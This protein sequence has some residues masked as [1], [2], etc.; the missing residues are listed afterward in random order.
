MA[1]SLD[2]Y[3][4]VK[5]RAQSGQIGLIVLLIMVVLLTMGLSIAAQTTQELFLSSQTSDSARVFN[6]A[7]AGIEQAL[8]TDL[9]FAQQVLEGE[10]T[11]IPNTDVNYSISKINTLQ[12][13]LFEGITVMVDV[14]GVVNGQAIRIDWS[15]DGDCNT[16]D[17]ASLLV[18]VYS[19]NAGV[20]SMRQ[21]A[22]GACNRSDGFTLASTLTPAQNNLYRRYDLAL[23]TND[24]FVRIKPVYNDTDIRVTGHQGFTL[25]TQ[26]YNIRSEARSQTG[27]ETRIVEVN[28]TLPT[29]PSI[30]DY[31]LYSGGSLNK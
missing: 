14:T 11:S 21:F 1:F 2:N 29:A 20:T 15:R 16:Q 24:L 13:R 3:R 17:P 9:D 5:H 26:Y 30:F 8:S 6:A 25:P 7:E 4:L 23:N 12:T 19:Q 31:A 28:Q 27:Q 10:V 22:L 18:S